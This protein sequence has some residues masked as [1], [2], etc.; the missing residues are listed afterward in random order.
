MKFS[1]S[2][3]SAS[4]ALVMISVL[5]ACASAKSICTQVGASLVGIASLSNHFVARSLS[6]SLVS[7]SLSLMLERAE[8]VAV[9]MFSKV[10]TSCI[11][12]LDEA[13]SFKGKV[14]S[15]TSVALN[16]N[17]AV[18]GLAAIASNSGCL[19]AISAS[20]S[21]AKAALKLAMAAA[22]LAC[23]EL[24]S[25]NCAKA[26][27][28]SDILMLASSRKTSEHTCSVTGFPSPSTTG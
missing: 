7:F 1:G 17:S 13:S 6:N 10:V 9:A 8:I 27:L 14:K 5:T 21:S 28:M 23:C 12:P 3:D 22:K 4:L 15:I 25:A 2:R 24:P 19:K 11:G 20:G 18:T 16:P 26:A